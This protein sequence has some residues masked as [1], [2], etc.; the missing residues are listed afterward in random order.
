VLF[1]TNSLTSP[2]SLYPSLHYHKLYIEIGT[3]VETKEIT[4][5]FALLEVFCCILLVIKGTVYLYAP[6]MS[7][8]LR[9]L[10]VVKRKDATVPA[11]WSVW[12]KKE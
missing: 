1:R 8:P 6:D 5:S 7:S 2:F 3:F 12:W 9:E 10:K 11:V 4:S